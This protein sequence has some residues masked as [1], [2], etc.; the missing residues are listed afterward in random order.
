MKYLHIILILTL[1]FSLSSCDDKI[2]YEYMANSPVYMSYDELRTSIE[3]TDAEEITSHGKIYFKDNYIFVLRNM[4]GIHM[5]DNSD[6][7]SPVNITYL[8]IPGVVDM[9]IKDNILFADSY[10]DMVAF[11]L[12]DLSNII[13]VNREEDVMPYTLPPYDENYPIA[14]IEQDSG[15]VVGWELKM[16]ITENNSGVYPVYGCGGILEGGFRISADV[17]NNGGG[18]TSQGVS[19][20]GSM[21]RFGILDETLYAVDM[22]KLHIFDISNA[23][24]PNYKTSCYVGRNVETMFIYDEKAFFGTRSGMTIYNLENRTAPYYISEFWHINSCDPVVV[25]DDL[26][27]ITLRGGNDCGSE[28]NHLEV[29]DISNLNKSNLVA[30]YEMKEPYGLGISDNTLFVCDGGAGL[31]I[32][33]VEDPETI[34]E[35]QLAHFENIDA[36]DVIPLGEV[37]ILIGE[38][39]LYQYDYSNPEDIQLLST[40]TIGQ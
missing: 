15:V 30:A 4:E 12:T 20:A 23:E 37:L 38:T 35:N 2:T 34:D 17:S 6:V 27:Y 7:E 29:I 33:S 39:G 5:I 11:D 3:Q 32:Y 40:I 19:I 13:E 28:V 36:Y 22:D 16:V 8:K 24:E 1:A 21:T 31:K 26:A 9:V 10:V 14:P 25:K 18:V